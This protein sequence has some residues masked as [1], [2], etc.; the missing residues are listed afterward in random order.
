MQFIFVHNAKERNDAK[1]EL[2]DG[3]SS[4]F[5]GIRRSGIVFLKEMCYS[6]GMNRRNSDEK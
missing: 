6:A 2:F 3:I 4:D 5:R 1:S